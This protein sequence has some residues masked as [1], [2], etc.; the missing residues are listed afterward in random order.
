[1]RPAGQD[2]PQ[3][4]ATPSIRTGRLA[5]RVDATPP[6]S[7]SAAFE[8]RGR[9]QEGELS[10]L[11]PLGSTAARLAWAPGS[12]TLRSGN[13]TRSFDSLDALAESATGTALPVAALFDW[14]AGT[15]TPVSGWEADLSQLDQGRLVARRVAPPP[16]AELRLVLDR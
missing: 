1:M 10:L 8:L 7:F 4:G 3:A 9:A 15:A 13:D 5:L 14:L 2:D 12:A 11:T 16:A 6:Q